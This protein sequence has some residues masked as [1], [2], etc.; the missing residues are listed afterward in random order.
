MSTSSLW[1]SICSRRA[2][3]PPSEIHDIDEI[4]KTF[5]HCNQLPV[6]PRHPYAG[7]LVF[8]A[9][10]GSHQDAIKKGL[11]AQAKSNTGLWEVPYLPIDPADLGRSYEAVIRINSQSGKG[12]VSYILEQG[13]GLRL[14][15]RLQI[16]FGQ[17][18]QRIADDSGKELQPADIWQAFQRE[19]LD[20]NGRFRFV[21]HRTAPNVNASDV[22]R[23]AAVI[24]DG[25]RSRAIEGVGQ[26]PHRRLCRRP[27]ART[28]GLDIR[29]ADYSEHAITG[30]TSEVGAAASAA[31]YVELRLDGAKPLFG[32]GISPNIVTASLQAV[33]S[34]VNRAL[35]TPGPG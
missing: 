12:G 2:S 31:A 7:E 28:Y 23:L 27:R 10:S 29:L 8:T 19:Y 11:A 4:V 3:I 25:G 22:R 34:A 14:P 13:H 26:R 5:E 15:R 18:I 20:G 17:V 16:E 32:V 9:F 35:R 21:E 30:T 1:P 6:D 33:T 24:E